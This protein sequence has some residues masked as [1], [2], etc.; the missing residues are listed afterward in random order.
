MV[1]NIFPCTLGLF[2]QLQPKQ[3]SVIRE[4]VGIAEGREEVLSL[5]RPI[6][7]LMREWTWMRQVW[8]NI[9]PSG[10]RKACR[11]LGMKRR[12]REENLDAGGSPACPTPLSQTGIQSQGQEDNR[13]RDVGSEDIC[14]SFPKQSLE[15][16][17]DPRGVCTE[18]PKKMSQTILRPRVVPKL[19]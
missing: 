18:G 13:L 1:L 19:K 14:S 17:Q 8:G 9:S 10:Q 16:Y 4:R 15:R 12:G 3:H 2:Q 7:E 11:G 6:P 5:V